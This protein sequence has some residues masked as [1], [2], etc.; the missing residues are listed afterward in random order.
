MWYYWALVK[1]FLTANSRHG[2]HSPFVYRLAEQVIYAEKPPVEP[3]VIF[4]PYFPCRY[5]SLLAA[6]LS[7]LELQEL[8]V[9]EAGK[10]ADA[11]WVDLHQVSTEELLSLLEHGTVIIVHEPHK[12][13]RLWNSIAADHRVV[14]SVDLFHFGVLIHREGQR[15]E[16]FVLRYPYWR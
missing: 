12:T 8:Q 10:Q 2:T 16:H 3:K 4:P 6:V 14:V 11:V 5:R 15:K 13:T 7:S 9:F 1:H